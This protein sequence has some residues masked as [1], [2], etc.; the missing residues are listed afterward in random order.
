ME[1]NHFYGHGRK[2]RIGKLVFHTTD[3][4][5][6]ACRDNGVKDVDIM[7]QFQRFQKIGIR[8]PWSVA[9]AAAIARTNTRKR[10][11]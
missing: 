1:N 9:A 10:L 11:L 8:V 4:I 6:R 5:Y 2:R 7:K 3:D